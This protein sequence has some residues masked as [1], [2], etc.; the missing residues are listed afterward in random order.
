M[1]AARAASPEV[2]MS[3]STLVP[4]QQ[5]LVS[6]GLAATIGLEEALLLQYLH[7]LLQ[8]LP[9]ESRAGQHWASA[10]RE[11]LLEALPF[12]DAAD[13]DRVCSR[14]VAIGILLVEQR[15]NDVVFAL[16][17]GQATAVTAAAPA[18]GPG[19]VAV[20]PPAAGAR[21]L[22][23]GWEPGRAVLEWLQLQHGIPAAFALGQVE[24]FT[25][26]WRERGE[27]S[28]AW[29][30]KFRQHVLSAWR[31]AQQHAGEAFRPPPRPLDGSWQPSADAM[32][33]LLRAGVP[34][35]FIQ[36]SIPEFVLYWRERGDPPKELNSRFLQHIRRQWARYTSSLDHGTEPTRIPPGWEPDAD[37]FDVLELSHI[38]LA[39]ARSLVPE[40][41][42]Y[43]RDSNEVHRSWN[44]KFLQ[45]VK[46]C[47]ARHNE[48][49]A[50]ESGHGG[51]QGAGGAGR[52]RD[53]SLEQDLRDTSWAD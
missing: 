31:R 1:L 30:N 12:W 22:P 33:I 36:D 25:F 18:P 42:L 46:W 3:E 37:V 41:V 28:H 24:D 19:G 44:S 50:Q 43:W 7:G 15:G 16:D 47:W 39:F 35:D 40:F 32:D 5:L 52:T 11:A 23:R 13:L 53:R 48:L 45:H 20:P 9:R 17:Q 26:Y 6:P 14:L 4:E 27:A 10:R 29:D 49:A 51:Q 34:R 8:H 38:D 2:S 21:A